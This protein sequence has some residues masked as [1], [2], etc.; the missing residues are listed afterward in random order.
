MY[1][2]INAKHPCF[3]PIL[4]PSFSVPNFIYLPNIKANWLRLFELSWEQHMSTDVVTHL[5]THLHCLSSNVPQGPFALEGNKNIRSIIVISSSSVISRMF[6]KSTTCTSTT[7]RVQRSGICFF[8]Q[9]VNWENYFWI[10][11]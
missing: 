7:F 10:R 3:S 4:L 2:L 9:S 8:D 6:E 5:Y 1:V 11:Q